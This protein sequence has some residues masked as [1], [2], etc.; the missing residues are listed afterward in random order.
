MESKDL[1]KTKKKK[2]NQYIGHINGTSRSVERGLSKKR[3]I[4]YLLVFWPLE[5]TVHSCQ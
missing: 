4:N 1:E 3:L 2:V 5:E